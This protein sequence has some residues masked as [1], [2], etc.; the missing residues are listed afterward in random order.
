VKSGK[1]ESCQ[2]QEALEEA[3]SL[4]N[5]YAKRGDLKKGEVDRLKLI[6]K[7]VEQEIAQTMATAT[8]AA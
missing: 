6:Q 5:A 7:Q 4:A 2:T 1:F 8:E 3:N